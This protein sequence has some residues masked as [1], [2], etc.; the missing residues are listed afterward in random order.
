MYVAHVGDSRIVAGVKNRYNRIEPKALTID[1]KPS[2]RS[3]IERIEKLGGQVLYKNGVPRVVWA[4]T[5][6]S[7][8][9]PVRRSTHVDHI[10]F[11]AVARSLGDLWSYQFEHED[12]LVSPEPDITHHI[13]DP[14]HHR[15]LV[16]GSDGL[17]NMMSVYDAVRQVEKYSWERANKS[18]GRLLSHTISKQL[19]Q[20][21]INKWNARSLRA[22]N[23]T[24]ITI[25]FEFPRS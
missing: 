2:N 7:H 17:W 3:E 8:T 11:L 12:Y 20:T 10:P 14:E 9:G 1:H 18:G 19:V 5:K 13:I 15:F 16:I 22:D 4:R 25:F 24:A 6:H 21:T 23:T